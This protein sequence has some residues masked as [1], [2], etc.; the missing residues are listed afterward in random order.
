[1]SD[2]VI[3]RLHGVAEL[4]DARF[5]CDEVWPSTTIGT[6]ITPNLLTAMEHAGG[7]VAAAYLASNPN[8]PI[9]AVISF[10]G[11]HR[12]S[13][14]GWETHLHSHMTA[15]LPEFR[16]RSFGTLFKFDQRSWCLENQVDYV[17]WTFDPLVRR[18]ARLNLVKLGAGVK[19]YLVNFYGE[20]LDELNAGDESDRMM[21]WW[22]LKSP[23]VEHALKGELKA[24]ETIPH[25]AIVIELPEDII[26]IRNSNPAVARAWREK[27]RENATTAL[28]QG[29]TLIG[30]D[31]H[32]SYV[33][34]HESSQ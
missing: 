26:E 5:V 13:S 32:D 15:V 33:F 6:E 27:V 21:A 10:L 3:R 34:A 25:D 18:N 28:S 30:L 24:L 20:M 14:G 31:A 16:D 12:D 17:S 22:D 2:I 19:E 1:M 8:A 11:R 7:Y 29:M 23:R 4:D 9:G